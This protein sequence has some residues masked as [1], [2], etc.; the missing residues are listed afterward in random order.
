[1]LGMLFMLHIVQNIRWKNARRRQHT[2]DD[3]DL[4][5]R[6]SAIRAALDDE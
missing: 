1:M 2:D 4:E 3:D 5:Q 6:R